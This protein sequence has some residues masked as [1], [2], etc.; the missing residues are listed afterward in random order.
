VAPRDRKP[1]DQAAGD[2]KLTDAGRK[3]FG[4]DGITPDYCVEPDAP[5]KFVSYL[6]G[7]QAFVNFSRNF[8]ASEYSGVAEIAGTGS[9]SDVVSTKVKPIRKDF[10]V[11]DKVIADFVA[12]LDTRKLT[13]TPADIE[14]NRDAIAR[15]ILEEVLRAAYGEGEARKRSMAWDP[16]VKKALE[17]VPRAELLLRNPQKFIAERQAEGRL[18]SSAGASDRQ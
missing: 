6:I 14:T 1:C 13:Y 9:R 2:A 15:Q 18:A 11:D 8:A 7:K 3:V 17:L 16:Q 12:Y 5:A 4:G 10:Q